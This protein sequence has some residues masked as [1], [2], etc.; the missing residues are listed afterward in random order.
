MELILIIY[1]N[2]YYCYNINIKIEI[3]KI[4][5]YYILE[6][7]CAFYISQ[8]RVAPCQVYNSHMWLM[9]KSLWQL[10]EIKKQKGDSKTDYLVFGLF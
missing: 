9:A 3:L 5:S 2:E 8:L 1:F 6:I 4:L 10:M 7:W